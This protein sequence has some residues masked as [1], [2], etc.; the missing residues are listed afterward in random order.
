MSSTAF[1]TLT[2]DVSAR[3][4]ERILVCVVLVLVLLALSRLQVDG[5][6]LAITISSALISIVGGFAL[7]GWLG[8]KRRLTRI[9]C[10]TD[11]RW[12]LCDATGRTIEREL[13][14]TSRVMS[15]A[16]W[17]RWR[18]TRA[19]ALMLLPGD[20]PA[21]DFRRLVVRLRLMPMIQRDKSH[22][23]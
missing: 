19:P 2:I 7:L 14:S 22:E 8:G 11:G 6:R 17:L 15:H 1:P 23:A 16:L 3:R 4:A 21:D 5:A 10:Q 13:A 18:G 9:A 12:A 20:I